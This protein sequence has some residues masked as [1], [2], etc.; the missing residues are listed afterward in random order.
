MARY[1]EEPQNKD[2]NGP[3]ALTAILSEPHYPLGHVLLKSRDAVEV[4]G[5]YDPPGQRLGKGS[6][7]S[8]YRVWLGG[9]QSVLKFTRDPSEAQASAFLRGKPHRNVVDIYEAWSLN[10]TNDRSL[11]GWYAIHRAYMVPLSKKDSALLDV[12]WVLYGD[13]SLD[14][15]FPKTHHRAML[16][17]WRNYIR[18]EMEELGILTAPSLHRCVTLLIETSEC[19]HALHGLGVDWE[20]IHSGNMMRRADGTMVIADVG[21]S[22]MHNETVVHVDDLTEDAARGYIKK[23]AAGHSGA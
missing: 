6:F 4:L 16:D 7:G 5:I 1:S 10:W 18:D 3:G 20:D 14:L 9:K 8:A 17:K 12:L 19:V 13:M 11:R 21:Y 2:G 22:S 23:L 15:K